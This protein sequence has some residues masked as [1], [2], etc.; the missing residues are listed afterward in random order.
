MLASWDHD[1]KRC[2]S[3][4]RGGVV[5]YLGGWLAAETRPGVCVSGSDSRVQFVTDWEKW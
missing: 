3:H 5:G 1:V 2:A 4:Y